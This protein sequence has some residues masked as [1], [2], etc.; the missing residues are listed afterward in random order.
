MLS[1]LIL[2]QRHE[3]RQSQDQLQ[4]MTSESEISLQV[5]TDSANGAIYSHELRIHLVNKS[6]QEAE[7]LLSH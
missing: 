1:F 7:K 3:A 6:R 2:P 5:Y 4:V